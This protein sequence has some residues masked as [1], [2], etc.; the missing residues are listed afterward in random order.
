MGDHVVDPDAVEP[1]PDRPCELRRL[2]DAAGF[3]R[4]AVN[5][6]RAD[7]G[8]LLPLAYH[9]HGEEAAFY[10]ASGGPPVEA[11]DGAY[12]TP[13]GSP[14]LLGPAGPHRAHVTAGGDPATV[15]AA[16]TPAID[17]AYDS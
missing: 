7:P 13:A 3:E 17:G 1:A 14:F 2:G 8:D 10:V 15:P 6:L 16:G 12:D 4:V 11:P 5:Q 9:H